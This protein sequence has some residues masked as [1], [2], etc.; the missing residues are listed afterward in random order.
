MARESTLA[1][2]LRG[3]KGG[4]S[5]VPKEKREAIEKKARDYENIEALK[6]KYRAEMYK[7][8][9]ET[10]EEKKKRLR[11][12]LGGAYSPDADKVLRQIKDG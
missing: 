10:E 4:K 8:P 3:S 7:K 1:L 6:A 12:L 5:S 11:T 2:L 9:G